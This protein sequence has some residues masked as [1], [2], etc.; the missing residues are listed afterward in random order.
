MGRFKVSVNIGSRGG[1]PAS[2]LSNFTERRFVFDGVP[3]ASIEG[4]L[5][6]FKFSDI[7]KQREV[8]ALI[9]AD[10]KKAGEES[11]WKRSQVLYWNRAEYPR[12]SQAY[13]DLLNRLFAEVCNQ[14]EGFARDLRE[15]GRQR[16]V[17]TIGRSDPAETVLTEKEFCGRLMRLRGVNPNRLEENLMIL[18]EKINQFRRWL[19]P[20][21]LVIGTRKKGAAARSISKN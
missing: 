10:A 19:A 7:Q 20:P 21:P 5:Q 6:S 11:D 8:C 3:C 2:R 16:L 13:Q 17:H 12:D 14:D 1:G 4:A 18:A 9:G 15:T